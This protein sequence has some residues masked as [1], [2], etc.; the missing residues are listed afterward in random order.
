MK[1]RILFP[2]LAVVLAVALTIP[3]ALVSAHE[4]DDP[5]VTDLLAGQFEDVG[6]VKV[7]ND[8]DNLHIT[9]EITDLDWVIT[10]THLYVGKNAAPTPAPGQF[11]YGDD[12][13]ASVSD[14]VVTYTIPLDDI[15]SYS[16]KL[17]NKGKPTG[18]MVADGDPG[19]E[20][21]N[22]VYI[23]AHAVV[24][25]ISCYQTAIVYGIER[26]TATVY[27]VDVLT[28]TSWMEFDTG[29][30]PAEGSA[31]PNGLAY[32]AENGRFYYCDY[33]APNTLYF[34]DTS[35]HVAG[36]LL[37]NVADGDFC[38]GKYYYIT[39]PPASDDLYEV[40]FNPD[41]TINTQTKLGDIADGLH[42]WTF[43]G[44]IAVKDGVVYGWG[45]CAPNSK[46]EFF[47]YG[48]ASDDFTLVTPSYQSSLQL[49]FGSDGTLY[50]HRSG[51]AGAFYV[52]DTADGDV[53]M[54]T[55]TPSPARLYTDC[56][57]GMICEPVTETAWGGGFL[58][59]GRSNWAMQFPYHVQIPPCMAPSG[60]LTITGTGWKSVTAWCPCAYTYDLTDAGE[61]IALQGWVDLSE[62]AVANTGDWSKY[63]AK[64][65]MFDSG[66]QAVEVVFCND[67][68]GDWYEM[69]AQQWDRI[70]MENNMG[71]AHPLRYY[72]T[73]GGTLGYDMDGTWVGPGNGATVYPSDGKYFF[74]LIADPGTE[75]FTLQVYGMGSGAPANPPDDWPKQNMYDYPTWLELGTITATGFDFSEVNICAILWAS[76]QAGA[77]DTT[78]IYWDGMTVDTPVTFGDIPE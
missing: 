42:G 12:D 20:P 40:T 57:S 75:T 28:G 61:P 62:A 53:T 39:G 48:L 14:T 59:E 74:Q 38:D 11:P 63:Y 13:A 19:V 18:V 21:C 37:G 43:N 47:T 70:R 9:Y 73:V 68:L 29:N 23:A 24:M 76:T 69:P 54:I 31:T 8:G 36:T 10:E 26:N 46:Y 41:G 52:V 7:W 67:W 5:Y 65:S 49:A 71:L 72:A 44:D 27:G 6:D 30:P 45:L 60:D 55:P 66:G 1:K 34:W 58:F 77:E 17:N 25:D 51:G 33:Y 3:M 56:A 4:E 22:Y 2:M 32:D 15:D 64:F 35:Q 50:G 16:M 78:T